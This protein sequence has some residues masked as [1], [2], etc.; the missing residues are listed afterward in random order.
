MENRSGAA[1]L[2]GKPI[3]TTDRINVGMGL[4]SAPGGGGQ[5]AV[6]VAFAP[7]SGASP[8]TIHEAVHTHY[9]ANL[10]VSD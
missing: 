8:Q 7:R 3:C 5:R 10:D 6:H 9:E 1:E 4:C 2:H